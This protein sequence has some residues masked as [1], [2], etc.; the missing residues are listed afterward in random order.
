[1]AFFFGHE[2]QMLAEYDGTRTTCMKKAWCQRHDG[3]H[4][5]LDSSWGGSW[6]ENGNKKWKSKQTQ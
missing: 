4:I 6:D 1:M 5:M 3:Q 2:Q